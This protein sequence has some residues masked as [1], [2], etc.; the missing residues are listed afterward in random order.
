MLLSFELCDNKNV[1][2][3]NNSKFRVCLRELCSWVEGN[4]EGFTLKCLQYAVKAMIVP[5]ES[6]QCYSS[7]M[8]H[9]ALRVLQMKKKIRK[10]EEVKEE[11]K[12]VRA[13]AQLQNAQKQCTRHAMFTT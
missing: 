8:H 7:S 3:S 13:R 10:R 2:K 9:R 12:V 1:H 11:E 6:Q 5:K 4:E